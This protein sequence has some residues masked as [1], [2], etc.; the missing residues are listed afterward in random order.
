[1]RKVLCINAHPDTTR[2][3]SVSNQLML[4][5][6]E[7]LQEYSDIELTELNVYD[8]PIPR[9]DRQMMEMWDKLGKGED[10]SEDEKKVL[11]RQGE[12]M[13][14]WKEADIFI[15]SMPLHNFN[16]PSGLKDLFDTVMVAGETFKYTEAGPIG[17]MD[18][19]QKIML[20]QASGSEYCKEE[21]YKQIDYAPQY[22][23]SAFAFMGMKDFRA[24]RA[25]GLALADTIEIRNQY[26]SEMLEALEEMLKQ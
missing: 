5:A 18:G 25:E 16:I 13:K 17:L 15:L 6:K 26:K 12:L 1:M 9:I 23:E 22:V 11:Q 3:T 7:K 10:P 2:M 19:H 14:L 24:I 20:I 21:Q 4:S 8:E